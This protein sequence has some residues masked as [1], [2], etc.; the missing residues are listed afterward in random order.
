MEILICN[1]TLND[2]QN[3]KQKCYLKCEFGKK[4]FIAK[5]FSGYGEYMNR[6]DYA[7]YVDG[8]IPPGEY[9]IFDRQTGGRLSVL[10]DLFRTTLNSDYNKWFALY[11]IDKKIDDET[12]CGKVRR[13]E[14]RLH[15]KGPSGISKGCITIEN[16]TK[17]LTLW[18]MLKSQ[19]PF[20]VPVSSIVS[21]TKK[22]KA[23][24]KVVVK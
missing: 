24:G 16:R 17:F 8:P 11:A 6:R 4:D 1:F 19:S 3:K 21:D 13:G 9:Y 14:F 2:E 5:A 12:Y 15:P 7:C 10:W 23:Y 22:L 18:S 20:V